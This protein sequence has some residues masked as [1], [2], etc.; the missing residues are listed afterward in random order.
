MFK[1]Q[2]VYF[3]IPEI[4]GTKTAETDLKKKNRIRGIIVILRIIMRSQ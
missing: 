4:K 3:V 1:N 2:S